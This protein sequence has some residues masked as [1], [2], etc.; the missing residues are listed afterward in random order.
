MNKRLNLLI[1]AIIFI[2][3]F[4][5]CQKETKEDVVNSETAVN[6]D[7]NAKQVLYT[8][9]LD[10]GIPEGSATCTSTEDD[11][12]TMN[13]VFN[14]GNI[15]GEGSINNYPY[16][17]SFNEKTY[18]GIYTGALM[19]GKLEGDCVF[20]A[21]GDNEWVYEGTIKDRSFS[22][23]QLSDFPMSISYEKTEIEGLYNGDVEADSISGIG[24]FVSK[25]G[26]FDYNGEWKDGELSGK[27]TLKYDGYIVHFSYVDRTGLYSGDVIN[28]IPIGEGSFTATNDEGNTYT[29]TGEWDNGIFNGQGKREFK[30]IKEYPIENGNFTNGDFTPDKLDYIKYLGSSE[31]LEYVVND[32][33]ESF[34]KDHDDLFPVEDN[35]ILTEYVDTEL[36]YEKYMKAPYEY[37]D[38][39][40]KITGYKVEQI[41]EYPDAG[42]EHVSEM[43]LSKDYGNK[44][45]R[46]FYLASTPDTYEGSTVTVYGLPV[47][48]SS[49]ANT[50]NG[51]VNCCVLFASD[52]A[53]K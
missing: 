49:Y 25:D 5:G 30:D 50:S 11:G 40:M 32:K 12:W 24:H 31:E 29:Y 18:D 16:S 1:L 23:G 46:V 19:D 20:T 34:I 2:F 51:F 27:G 45:F 42:Y 39:L 48:S 38:K 7:G 26:K 4:S 37:G 9:T 36:T 43:I 14:T 22:K 28:G 44:I 33:A 8:G 21:K 15:V 53:K 3:C 35:S 41:W 10:N 47:A 6:I 17:L 13:A 52:V